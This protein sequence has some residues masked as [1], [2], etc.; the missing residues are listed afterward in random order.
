MTQL[1]NEEDASGKAKAVYNEIKE[2]FGMVPNFFL[3]QGAVDPEW[4]ELNWNRQKMIMLSDGALDRKT[5]E[6]LAMAV[7]LSANCEYCSLAHETT[8][9]MAGATQEEIDE[10]KKII[11]L[12]SSFSAIATS[13]RVPCD[14][15]PAM[16][17]K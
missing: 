17:K 13:L 14:L 7:S 11:E 3:A 1:L 8:A 15:N 4:L 6:I 12:F 10:A 16:L 5:K 2:T 9:M